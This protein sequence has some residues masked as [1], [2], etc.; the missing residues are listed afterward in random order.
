MKQTNKC[1]V[2]LAFLMCTTMISE[3]ISHNL[4]N[5]SPPFY[6]SVCDTCQEYKFFHFHHKIAFYA[7]FHDFL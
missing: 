3:D 4:E 2:Y 5:E 6:S 7:D 1:V